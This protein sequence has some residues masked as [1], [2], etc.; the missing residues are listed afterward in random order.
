MK[1]AYQC[2]FTMFRFNIALISRDY[3]SLKKRAQMVPQKVAVYDHDS[4]SLLT[5]PHGVLCWP[6]SGPVHW[7]HCAA[8]LPPLKRQWSALPEHQGHCS[9]TAVREA[10]GPPPCWGWEQ[11]QYLCVG[12]SVSLGYN[13]PCVGICSYVHTLQYHSICKVITCT[14]KRPQ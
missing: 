10:L 13:K 9:L 4:F 11:V 7:H 6:G 3:E 14:L 5:G 2:F 1:L 8:T 12:V